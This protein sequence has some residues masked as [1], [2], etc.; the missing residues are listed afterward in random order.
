MPLPG[1]E[2]AAGLLPPGTQRVLDVACGWGDGTALLARQFAAVTGA[3][4]DAEQIREN[5]EAHPAA[6]FV[7]GDATDPSLFAESSFEAIVSIHSMEHFPDD[8]RVRTVQRL[9]GE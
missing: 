1:Y 4:Y 6:S 8:E 9:V 3:D 2:Q 7:A 5:V